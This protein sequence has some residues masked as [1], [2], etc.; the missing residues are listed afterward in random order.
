M[1]E[2][3]APE[4]IAYTHEFTVDADYQRSLNRAL[5]LSQFRSAYPWILLGLCLF[6]IGVSILGR[7]IPYA[8]VMWLL[9]VLIWGL[10]Y[11]RVRSMVRKIFPVGKVMRTGFSSTHFAISDGDNASVMAYSGFDSIEQGSVVVWLRRKSPR[12]RVAYP[13]ALFPDAEV[14][15][16]RAA[17]AGAGIPPA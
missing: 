15:A 9:I 17:I 10:R 7:S 3:I 5:F 4:S 16:I 8:V 6:L 13:R 14:R 1:P 11:F 2:A 12:R